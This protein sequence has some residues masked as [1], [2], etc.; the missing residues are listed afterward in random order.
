[1]DLL[2]RNLEL[3]NEFKNLKFINE[4]S[5]FRFKIK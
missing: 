1:M 5:L 3:E 2:I 4:I